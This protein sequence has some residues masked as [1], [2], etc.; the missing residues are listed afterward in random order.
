VYFWQILCVLTSLLSS[1]VLT[2]VSWA[3]DRKRV[4]VLDFKVSKDAQGNPIVK[5]FDAEA[6]TEAL[7]SVIVE[8]NLYQVMTKENIYDL[9]E[10]GTN[11]EDCVGKCEVETGR[12]LGAH[13]IITGVLG[14]IEGRYDLLIRLY[15]TKNS[16]LLSSKN[17]GGRNISELRKG[18]GDK[19]RL[20]FSGLTMRDAMG[21]STEVS[22]SLL[23][24]SYQPKDSK[25]Q[26]YIDDRFID[27]KDP[28]IRKQE[29]GYLIPVQPDRKHEIKLSAEGYITF[30]DEVLVTKGGVENV[31]AI[32]AK[33]VKQSEKCTDKSCKAVLFVFTSPVGAR[34][35]IDGQAIEGVSAITNDANIGK[36]RV[37]GLSPGE[38]VV[39]VRA[40]SYLPAQRTIKLKRGGFNRELKK[41]PIKLEP[42]FGKIRINTTPQAATI[43]LDG[44]PVANQSPYIKNQAVVGAHKLK[45]TA[46][47]HQK[48]EA[49]IVVKRGQLTSKE[50]RL[51][52]DYSDLYFTVEEA[53]GTPITGA[54]V[55]FDSGSAR[56]Q[57]GR[58]VSGG[59]GEVKYPKT[60]RG[61]H[62]IQVSHPMYKP[63]ISTVEVKAGG[64]GQNERL[65]L[66]ANY[67]WLSIRELKGVAGEVFFD[68]SRSL[69]TLPLSK[70]KIPV[71][72]HQ[73][74]IQPEDSEGF[75]P[76]EKRITVALKQ[77]LNQT[78]RFK[79]RLGTLEVAV[80]PGGQIY[81]DGSLKGEDEGRFTLRRGKHEVEV[82]AQGYKDYRR[83][84]QIEEGQSTEL[85]VNLGQH[86]T[87]EVSCFPEE[88]VVWVQ[89]LPIGQGSQKHSAPPGQW[90][91][92][93]RIGDA[94]VSQLITL[95]DGDTQKLNLEIKKEFIASLSARRQSMRR[96]GWSLVYSGAALLLGGG[97]VWL[98]PVQSS[99]E[100]RNQ[101]YTAYINASPL[102]QNAQLA[103]LADQDNQL[104]NW[105]N[106]AIISSAT[107]ALLSIIGGGLLG[108]A[109]SV[110]N[111]STQDQAS[112]Q[113]SKLLD[114]LRE[115]ME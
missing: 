91:V 79:E 114:Q 88:A 54:Q 62:Q 70:V 83:S 37:K 48:Y 29:D 1:F 101:T 12:N 17:V 6:L 8:L 24:F 80:S 82:K 103:N 96:W 57:S 108:L 66:Q 34:V 50:I 68:D 73:L 78:P 100:S 72:T 55:T 38:H 33:Q 95:R 42:N 41:N 47:D 11:L 10:P 45:I 7:R 107:G 16:E 56:Q 81:V 86:P 20:M 64:L 28:K 85:N 4:A 3:K 112:K 35:F 84:V 19:T 92:S 39:E 53:N 46:I 22:D 13:Y 89:G 49:V 115:K 69:G 36:L 94:Q 113:S 25:V 44:K 9:L 75:Q 14:Q 32:L 111:D 2:D 27:L 67:G 31:S 59:Q 30:K 74:R 76:I 61:F 58:K 87:L 104:Q 63:L 5:S 105:Q 23:Y 52:P 98:G 102:E 43:E 15:E 97:G 40:E 77:K 90:S 110:E 51:I 99:I 71:G 60:P 106:V 109:P 65:Q 93:C 26:L 18:I 21:L